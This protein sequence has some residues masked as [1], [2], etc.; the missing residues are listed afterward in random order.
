MKQRVLICGMGVIGSIYALRLAKAGCL[1]TG[2]ARGERLAALRARGVEIHNIFTEETETADI[3]VVDQVPRREEFDMV[4][5]VVRSGQILDVL[6][7]LRESHVSARAVAVIGNNMEDLEGQAAAAGKDRFVPGFGA[8]G[9]YREGGLIQYL[10]GR[11]RE[12]NGTEQR[13]KT[14]LGILGAEARPALETI[15]AML[16]A[17]GLLVSENPDMRAWFLYHAALV[18]PLAGAIYSAGGGQERFCRTR[19]AIVLGIRACHECTRALR[20]LGYGIQPKSLKSLTIIPE[21]AMARLLSQRMRGEAARVAMFGHA[22]APGGRE[23]ISGQAA[24]LDRIVSRSGKPL[25]HWKRL[26]PYFK[27]LGN[28]PLLADGSRELRLRVW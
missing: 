12:K 18:F 26:L 13:S 4:M 15:R 25:P 23:E 10:D 19:D 3:T 2:L 16:T 1:V 7:R 24:V 8:F 21:W 22:N 14:T 28:A 17:A 9:G 27:Q 20:S 5:V 6:G 11:T